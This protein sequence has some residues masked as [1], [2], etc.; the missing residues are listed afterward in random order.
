MVSFRKKDIDYDLLVKLVFSLIN[1]SL[2]PSSSS[3][4]S[5]PP[6]EKKE[7]LDAAIGCILIFLPGVPEINLFL[8]FFQTHFQETFHAN[9]RIIHLISLHSNVS[10]EDQLKIFKTY[11]RGHLKI[12]AS[13]N[14]AEASVTIPDCTVVIDCCRVKEMDYN[15]EMQAYSL[16]MKFA[17]KDSLRQRKGRAGRVRK[18]S[19][20]RL[21]TKGTFE[22]LPDHSIPEILRLPL[23]SVLLQILSMNLLLSLENEKNNQNQFVELSSQMIPPSCRYIFSK[24]PNIPKEENILTA[25]QVLSSLQ[26]VTSLSSASSSSSPTT[27]TVLT[28]LGQLLARLPC[29]PRIGRL[30]VYGCLLDCVYPITCVAAAITCRSPFIMSNDSQVQQRV[31]NAKVN[32]IVSPCFILLLYFFA[33]L[34]FIEII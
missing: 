24:C 7:L 15:H 17:S 19:C 34:S 5:Q 4:T 29:H 25:L 18:G 32:H 28:S 26:A 3:A 2:L 10:P 22:K 13:T 21:I 23:E 20:Y 6:P 30:L 31:N 12:I 33:S 9:G 11:P 16:V 14:I 8:K 1:P 27:T